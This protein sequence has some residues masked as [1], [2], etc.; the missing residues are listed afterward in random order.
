[1][2]RCVSIKKK[3]SV[4]QCTA[5][6]LLGHTMCGR[7]ARMKDPVIWATLHK[8]PKLAKFQALFR[9]WMVRRFLRLCGPGVLARSNVIN[10]EDLVTCEEKNKQHPFDYVGIEEN[11]KV[12]WFDFGTIYTWSSQSVEPVNPYSKT[13]LSIDVRRRLREIW[14]CKHQRRE[15]LPKES[16]IA[17]ERMRTRWNLLCQIFREYG[18]VD[19]H[20]NMFINT[21]KANYYAM[22]HMIQ[23]DIQVS[24]GDKSYYKDRVLRLCST[25]IRSLH[26]TDSV[27]YALASQIGLYIMMMKPKDPYI[28]IFAI[29]SA[30]HRC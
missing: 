12:W 22:F 7:H 24:V 29:M 21:I 20:P 4:E 28:V 27:R 2:V 3:G 25:M 5:S 18:F 13:P 23:D 6:H 15:P 30:L 9:G 17:T 1:M 11:G 19:V 26:A 14:R 16:T 10:D 8:T